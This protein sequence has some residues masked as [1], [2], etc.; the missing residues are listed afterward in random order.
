MDVKVKPRKR[1]SA[2]RLNAEE[3]DGRPRAEE[4]EQP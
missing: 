1:K 2:G 4:K 3:H